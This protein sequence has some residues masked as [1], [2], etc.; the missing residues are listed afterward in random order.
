MPNIEIH[1]YAD[2][3]DKIKKRIDKCM[4]DIGLGTE[5]I[6]TKFSSV[7]KVVTAN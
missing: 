1:G 5:A 3:S 2:M 7:A 4:Q 6:T